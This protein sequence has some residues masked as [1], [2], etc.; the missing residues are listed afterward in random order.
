MLPSLTVIHIHPCLLVIDFLYG[1]WSEFG[2]YI[3]IYVYACQET[4]YPSPLNNVYTV[5]LY[6]FIYDS[7][8]KHDVIV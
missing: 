3:Y 4:V 1:A 7:Y 2:Q 6:N 8:I 5:L